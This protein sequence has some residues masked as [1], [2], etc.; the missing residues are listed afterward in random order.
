MA[1]YPLVPH[2]PSMAELSPIQECNGGFFAP[3]QIQADFKSPVVC[4]DCKYP[5][6]CEA[7]VVH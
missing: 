4:A 3:R 2:Y 5:I 7:H 6:Y 1:V